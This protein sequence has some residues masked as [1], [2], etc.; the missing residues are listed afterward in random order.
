MRV[1]AVFILLLA[2][3]AAQ[4]KLPVIAKLG[5]TQML[6]KQAMPF[7]SSTDV[8]DQIKRQQ[9]LANVTVPN[10]YHM[11]TLTPIYSSQLTVG[12]VIN[13][14]IHFAGLSHP[15][16]LVGSDPVS[17]RWLIRYHDRLV[18]LNAVGILVQA[19]H[20]SDVDAM[21]ALADGLTLLPM[22]GDAFAKLL[23]LKHYPVLISSQV[24]EQ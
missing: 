9:M 7:I 24:V 13:H 1:S 12:K 20:P 3:F 17:K 5:Q 22:S 14:V 6:P 23:S 19:Q 16:F 10:D 11:P 8:I 21:Q 18:Q 4:A 15:L 2:V